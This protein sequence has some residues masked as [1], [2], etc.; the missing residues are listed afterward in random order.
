MDTYYIK[1]EC[2]LCGSKD[3]S[4]ALH[5]N[6][7]PLCDAYIP[8][9]KPQFFYPLDLLLCN[10]CNFVQLSTVVDPEIIYRDYIYTTTSSLGLSSHFKQYAN[11]VVNSLDLPHNSFFVDIGSND[12]TLLKYFKEFRHEVLGVEPSLHTAKQATSNGI[13]TLPDFFDMRLSRRIVHEYGKA[14]VI[15]INNLFANVDNLQDFVDAIVH[16]MGDDGVL[17]IESSYLI[18]MINNMVFDF[19]YHEHLSYLSLLPLIQFFETFD[20]K[21]IKVENIST[22]GGSLRYYWAKNSSKRSIDQS[23]RIAVNNELKFNLSLDTF[24]VYQQQINTTKEKF[25]ET[26]SRYPDQIIAGYGASA[27]STT[28]ISHFELNN[29]LK[30]LV[31]DNPGKIDTF[32]PGYHIPVHSPA[33][34]DS[35]PPDSVVVLAWRF[36]NAIIPKIKNYNCKIFV[37][38]PDVHV[39]N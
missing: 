39:V 7:S 14:D 6:H 4:L 13:Y 29:V 33:V 24:N 2:R 18:D 12:G 17:I 38:L 10:A 20:L 16:L 26:I 31:D 37:P 36:K 19:I 34:L 21:L 30:Y 27:T 28:L 23:V 22:K 3:L 35:E 1:T 15:T 32:S 11:E 5:L 9:P 8:K 25:L